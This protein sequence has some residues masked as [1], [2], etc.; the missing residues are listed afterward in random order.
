MHKD[1]AFRQIPRLPLSPIEVIRRIKEQ[2]HIDQTEA[3]HPYFGCLVEWTGVLQS[4]SRLKECIIVTL[5][6]SEEWSWLINLSLI[7]EMLELVQQLNKGD[8]VRFRGIITDIGSL[9]VF[10]IDYVEF[11][12]ININQA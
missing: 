9:N 11:C 6:I 7:P 8:V 10:N 1:G 4:Y 5:T 3:A 2:T 12:D